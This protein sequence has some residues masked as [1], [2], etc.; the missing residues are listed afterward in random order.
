MTVYNHDNTPKFPQR[1][2]DDF[3]HPVKGVGR[4]S[5]YQL[6]STVQLLQ[7]AP[8]QNV[9]PGEGNE[10]HD[11]QMSR[12]FIGTGQT[13][14]Q[15]LSNPG[16]DE[17]VRPSYYEFH[18]L[19]WKGVP[20]AAIING[21]DYG[22]LPFREWI[23]T[24]YSNYLYDGVGSQNNRLKNAGH[25]PR[26]LGAEGTAATFGRTDPWDFQSKSISEAGPLEDAGINSY[27]TE[28]THFDPKRWRGVPS[29]QAL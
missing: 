13:N 24:W 28:D 23:Y 25:Y 9:V 2:T 29:A 6:N 26:M 7:D 20:S 14:I 3:V 22:H 17:D 19:E 1:S 27:D 15:P 11:V 18:F 5:N 12:W 8:L 16:G 4:Y 21:G 10:P